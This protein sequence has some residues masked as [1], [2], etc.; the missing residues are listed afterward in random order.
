MCICRKMCTR[1]MELA[2]EVKFYLDFH[3]VTRP[4]RRRLSNESDVKYVFPRCLVPYSAASQFPAFNISARFHRR[5]LWTMPSRPSSCC[6]PSWNTAPSRCCWC[7]TSLQTT[8]PS[9]SPACTTRSPRLRT[10]TW[11]FHCSQRYQNCVAM[12]RTRAKKQRYGRLCCQRNDAI[13]WVLSRPLSCDDRPFIRDF[14]LSCSSMW[15]SGSRHR[16]ALWSSGQVWRARSWRRCVPV[17]FIT[18]TSAG[19]P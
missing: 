3:W 7:L 11:P 2:L 1:K 17:A 12:V 9:S 8:A 6:P 19:P 14:P 5:S 16:T 18:R 15:S 4:W 10:R 13:R